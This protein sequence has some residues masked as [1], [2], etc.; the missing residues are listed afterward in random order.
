MADSQGKTGKQIIQDIGKDAILELYCD[1]DIARDLKEATRRLQSPDTSNKDFVSLL[2]L[3]W[4]F[5]LP[6]PKQAI[7]IEADMP[8]QITINEGIIEDGKKH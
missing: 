5:R 7:G 2:R 6:K 8:I 3:I 1:E 4:D